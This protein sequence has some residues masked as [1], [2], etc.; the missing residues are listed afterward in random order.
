[1]DASHRLMHLHPDE[2]TVARALQKLAAPGEPVEGGFGS[3]LGAGLTWI[4][5]QARPALALSR[6]DREGTVSLDFRS[7]ES[8]G[9]EP[10]S[11][12]FDSLLLLRDYVVKSVGPAGTG[13]VVF[14]LPTPRNLV[15]SGHGARCSGRPSTF[16]AA[17]RAANGK[18]AFL[19]AGHGAPDEG[20]GAYDA[21]GGE[22][23]GFVAAT[24]YP[25]RVRPGVVTPD[26]AVIEVHDPGRHGIPQAGW[27]VARG[28]EGDLVTSYGSVTSGR[29]GKIFLY[30]EESLSEAGP[31]V[32]L[33][34]QVF[35]VRPAI[36]AG[37]DSGAVVVDEGSSH[38]L[39]HI[40]AGWPAVGDYEGYSMFQD[41]DYQLGAHGVTLA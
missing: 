32:G 27:Q 35:M 14:G 36:S 40:V 24:V 7:M 30:L 6:G 21:D 1:M 41:L 39:G 16:G 3:L 17:V 4:D 37:G 31:A 38:L 28:R 20:A 12:E 10:H 23:V 34:G 22:L 8:D 15:G 13:V 26:V 33:L 29:S 19:T 9:L 11:K 25:A 18:P 2:M 5:G